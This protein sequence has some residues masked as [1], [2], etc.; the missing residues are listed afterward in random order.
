MGND[1]ISDVNGPCATLMY[2]RVLVLCGCRNGRGIATKQTGAR[3]WWGEG[4]GGTGRGKRRRKYSGKG[5]QLRGA[6]VSK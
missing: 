3:C 6:L 1:L 2:I 5:A 4:G